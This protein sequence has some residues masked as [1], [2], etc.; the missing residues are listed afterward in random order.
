MRIHAVYERRLV[1]SPGALP[2]QRVRRLDRTAHR[3]YRRIHPVDRLGVA[4]MLGQV[5]RSHQAV[6]GS[7]VLRVGC[8]AL[9]F[10]CNVT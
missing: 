1:A 3:P 5:Q 2:R 9:T 10:S 7:L 4:L 8:G 6:V